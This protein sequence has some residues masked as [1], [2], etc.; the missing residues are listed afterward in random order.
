MVSPL[1]TVY[2]RAN[3]GLDLFQLRLRQM[4][5]ANTLIPT[6]NNQG[7]LSGCHTTIVSRGI[8]AIT[9]HGADVY[10]GHEL[11]TIS[12]APNQGSDE[13][14]TQSQFSMLLEN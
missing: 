14:K 12:M 9:F 7:K 1:T 2:L 5:P 11:A 6:E 8:C 13:M 10:S 3:L 4:V